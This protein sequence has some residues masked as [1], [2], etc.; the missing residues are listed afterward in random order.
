MQIEVTKNPSDQLL[1]QLGCRTWATWEKSPSAFPWHYEDKETCL[2]IAGTVTVTPNGG[3]PVTIGAGD[4][5]VFPKGMSC[6]WN[7]QE[8]IR[9][10]YKFGG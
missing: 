6:T 1:A 4:L 3:Q 2:I 9:K 7:V 8:T 10:H 5:V